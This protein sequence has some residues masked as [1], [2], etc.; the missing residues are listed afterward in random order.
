VG[1]V[2][3]GCSATIPT[4]LPLAALPASSPLLL[5]LLSP[6]I[7]VL[8]YLLHT[9]FL[10]KSTYATVFAAS[11]VHSLFL[12]SLILDDL[13]SME[14]DCFTMAT[15][16]VPTKL[17][18]TCR[19]IDSDYFMPSFNG[20][21]RLA[22]GTVRKYD[23]MDQPHRLELGI[24]KDIVSRSVSCSLCKFIATSF[25]KSLERELSS[26]RVSGNEQDCY[27]VELCRI[28]LGYGCA[29]PGVLSYISSKTDCWELHKL[30][31]T[32]KDR[33]TGHHEE[34]S[35]FLA[36]PPSREK[37]SRKEKVVIQPTLLAR[38]QSALC[39]VSLFKSWLRICTENHSRCSHT[40]A[41]G[42]QPLRLVDVKNMCL[43]TFSGDEKLNKRY[44]ALSY[45]W[46]KGDKSFLLTRENM[47]EY[48]RHQ[49][50]PTLPKTIADAIILTRNM[51]ERYLW[52]DSLCIISN[53]SQDKAAQIPAMASI[54]G[55]AILTI[56]A[57][58][59]HDADTSIPGVQISRME[60]KKVNL[61]S[62]ELVQSTPKPPKF[63]DSRMYNQNPIN[64]TKWASRAWTYQELLLSPRSLVFFDE[65]VLWNCKC[66]RW[67]EELDLDHPNTTFHWLYENLE[68]NDESLTVE[69]YHE[70]VYSYTTRELTIEDDVVDAFQGIMEAIPEKFFWGI[71]LSRFGDYFM[72]TTFR[73]GE[74]PARRNCGLQ[75]PTWS[76]FAWK[77]EI[78][79]YRSDCLLTISRWKEDR[80][81]QISAPA[82]SATFRQDVAT[83]LES[84]EWSVKPDDIPPGIVLNENQLVFWAL[85]W[86]ANDTHEK[87]EQV[88]IMNEHEV[89]KTI[90]ISWHNHVAH[91]EGIPTWNASHED[92]QLRDAVKKLIILE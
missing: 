25:P 13:P 23:N 82:S 42:T 36:P 60:M 88:L 38:S 1:G 35:A 17:C 76:W 59:G 54:Y 9:L 80:L 78:R 14:D 22:D 39:E 33:Y 75:I 2:T 41:N 81:H 73:L 5:F 29:P 90:R 19:K 69:N 47:Q 3:I 72:W 37:T 32:C 46:G 63:S 49:G 79:I 92:L 26:L 67:L 71:P 91:R 28:V 4:R 66:A 21:V 24:L 64:D 11:A 12:K 6:P 86:E 8:R 50:I 74:N 83:R 44:F 65:Q 10:A 20:Y 56:V 84:S 62:C 48:N 68:H 7:H 30:T 34:L 57:A 55:C 51:Q 87:H 45:V 61:G 16:D 52:V 43:V 31:F 15:I 40:A 77:G 85:V 18:D 70:L 89:L 58:A 27:L 53:D